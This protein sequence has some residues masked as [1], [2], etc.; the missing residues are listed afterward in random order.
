MT[1]VS[2]HAGWYAL[3]AGLVAALV[4][5]G[6]LQYHSSRQ[7]SEAASE[8]MR[9]NLQ[10]SLMNLRRG[11]EIELSAICRTLRPRIQNDSTDDLA[12]LANEYREWH[13]STSHPE[14]IADILVWDPNEKGDAALKHLNDGKTGFEPVQWPSELAQ[15]HDQ[16]S[17]MSEVHDSVYRNMADTGSALTHAPL[18]PHGL[19][20]I[21]FP[22][23]I[24][25]HTPALIQGRVTP[26]F[27]EPAMRSHGDAS[28]PMTWLIVR[29]NPSA[30]SKLIA[31]LVERYFSGGDARTYQVAV[32]TGAAGIPIVYSSDGK[33]GRD[34]TQKPD[35]TLNMFGPPF[36]P[37]SRGSSSSAQPGS[38]GG[39]AIFTAP[40]AQ[41]AEH[42]TDEAYRFAR[43]FRRS[44]RHGGHGAIALSMAPG[45]EP[46]SPPFRLEPLRYGTTEG[47]WV[48]IAKH[49]QGSLEAAVNTV[50]YRNLVLN[51]GV[52]AILA[53]TAALIIVISARARRLAQLQVDFVTGVSHEL[54]T[55]LTGIV[56][57]A[58]NLSDGLV[59]GKDQTARYGQAILGQAR[60]LSDLIEQILIFSAVDK[61][62]H[63]YHLQPS[64]VQE[65]IEASLSNT[66]TMIRERGIQAEKA[67]EPNL[68]QVCVDPKALRQCLQNLI[69]NAIKYGGDQRWL[70]VKA[71]SEANESG[72]SWVSI[73]V[74][75]RGIGIAARDL[76][77]IF[78]PFFRSESVIASQIHGSGLGLPLAKKMVEAMGGTLTV[79]SALGE[80]S[81]LTIH[82]PAEESESRSESDGDG[83]L[84][85]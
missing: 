13:S 65:M 8:Q 33:F 63:R 20:A 48:I 69:T 1:T 72:K 29:L 37:G 5:L 84:Q 82:L 42:P 74:E 52:L 45:V 12:E 14:L 7:L 46:G 36:A 55:P 76:S 54:R 43:E 57:A 32:V 18:P 23:M 53:I 21:T 34:A 22:W 58:Q 10:A 47:D 16:L 3:I 75:D 81:T 59:D 11:V 64:S 6:F 25:E 31:E 17:K 39:Q 19:H 61:E 51:F 67:I 28:P 49:R 30:L 44:G 4:L 60:Q 15:L 68:P 26:P 80:G 9:M 62:G 56:S 2:K 85:N 78:Q 24:D 38:P 41:D 73:S 79:R 70:R 50:F 77:Q 27:H 83:P 71:A 35:A 40:Q 66:A